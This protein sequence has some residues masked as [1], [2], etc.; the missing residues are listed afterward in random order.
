MSPLLVRRKEYRIDSGG[1]GEYRGGLGQVMEVV[2]LDDAAFAISANYDRVLYPARGR[3]GGGNGLAG[4][5]SLG[6]GAT[7]KSKGQQT[8]A[9]HESVIIEMPGGG[10]LGNPLDRDP[11]SVA[12]DVHLGMVSRAA[13][14]RDYGVIL[15]DD[16]TI[17]HDATTAA[18]RSRRS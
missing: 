18:R 10:G 14:S 12:E 17:D 13:A 8:I 5:L 2:T 9:K 3:N 11:G 4:A 1:A 6:S 7:L 15:H 16:H